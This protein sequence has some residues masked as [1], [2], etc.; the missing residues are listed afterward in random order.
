MLSLGLLSMNL[1]C[2]MDAILSIPPPPSHPHISQGQVHTQAKLSHGDT[3]ICQNLV[4][5]C[6][7]A[8]TFCQ[9]Q[10]HC[11]NIILILRSKVKV[12]AHECTWH[13]V[14][15]WYTHKPNKVWLCQKTK[16]LRPEHK[17]CH[18]PYK[19]DPEVK[20]QGCIRIMDV[21]DTSSHG[22]RPMCQI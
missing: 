19:F 9:T 14:P 6:L 3:S 22:D 7:R 16:K 8:K 12:I 18:K 10:I 15:W 4:C 13:I 2:I 20:V 5:L 21:L 1:K 11:E 17:A